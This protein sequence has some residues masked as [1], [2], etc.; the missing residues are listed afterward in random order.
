MTPGRNGREVNY[1]TAEVMM[2]D[3]ID[4]EMP[5][6][7]PA[8]V[9]LALVIWRKTIGWGKLAE[10]VG[11]R[12]LCVRTKLD[13]DTI[14][15]AILPLCKGLGI[16]TE[17]SRKQGVLPRRRY[18]WPINERVTATLA[19]TPG[20][21]WVGGKLPPTPGRQ[22]TPDGEGELTPEGGGQNPPTQ[23]NTTQSIPSKQ[24]EGE[25]LFPIGDLSQYRDGD[26]IE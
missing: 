4:N 23:S 14:K 24:A 8:E 20:N 17:Q 26:D 10:E 19:K 1:F 16:R 25:L 5:H 7:K 2:N 3:F 9:K 21:R 22:V 15:R 12:E 6:L 11:T 13:R 18:T